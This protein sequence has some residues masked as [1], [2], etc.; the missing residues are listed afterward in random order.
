MNS[1]NLRREDASVVKVGFYRA[2][3]VTAGI[4]W[5]A[6]VSRFW[7]PAEARRELSKSLSEFSVASIV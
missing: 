2:I 7:W 5:A 6:L 4:L 1:Y 3:A